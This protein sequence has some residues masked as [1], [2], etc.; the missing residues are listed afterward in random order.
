M[1]PL[2]L[3]SGRTYIRLRRS[4]Y[5]D[6]ERKDWQERIRNW[7]R[8]GIEVLVYIKHEDNPNAP[9]IALQFAEGLS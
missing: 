2:M 9:L 5:S 6:A 1:T 4:A 3:T 8:D 7:A